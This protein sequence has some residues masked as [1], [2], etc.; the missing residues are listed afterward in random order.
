MMEI[1]GGIDTGFTHSEQEVRNDQKGITVLLGDPV[2]SSE[3]NA[4]MEQSVFLTDE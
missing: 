3:I 1:N 4:Q 2:Q